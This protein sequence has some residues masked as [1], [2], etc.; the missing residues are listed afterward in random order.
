[1]DGSILAITF[2]E[3]DRNCNTYAY[4]TR[5]GVVR[6]TKDGG[7]TWSDLDPMKTLPDVPST[8]SPSI[9]PTPIVRLSQCPSTMRRHRPSIR[10]S[11]ISVLDPG[12]LK[13]TPKWPPR[14]TTVGGHMLAAYTLMCW[15]STG[16]TIFGAKPF[17]LS[18][19]VLPPRFA[20]WPTTLA[21]LAC[22]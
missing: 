17:S 16:E 6:M 22:G 3:S 8:A 5:A 18:W 15:L 9:R 11:T 19:P 7:T 12:F 20:L 1:L 4:S 13:T 14:V 10:V 2:V 21:W